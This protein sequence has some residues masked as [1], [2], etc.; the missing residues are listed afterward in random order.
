MTARGSDFIEAGC[1]Q[2]G[3]SMHV[4]THRDCCNFAEA[5]RVMKMAAHKHAQV[6]LGIYAHVMLVDEAAREQLR[7]LVGLS[8][9][10]AV[11]SSEIPLQFITTAGAH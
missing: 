11:G 8:D 6:T 5:P 3:R 4:F 7:E 2:G 10:A 1:H 9:R